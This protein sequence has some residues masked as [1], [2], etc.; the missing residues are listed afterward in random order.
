MKT[1]ALFIL[2]AFTMVQCS[3]DPCDIQNNLECTTADNDGDGVPN[4]D[5][6]A[7]EDPCVPNVPALESLLVGTWDYSGLASGTMKMNED[8]SYEDIS[9]EL[10][11]NGTVV[12]RIW[13][14]EAGRAVKWEVQNTEGLKS[15]VTLGILSTSCS[16]VVF[17]FSGLSI[18]FEKV[19]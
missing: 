11:N 13:S 4:G 9:N 3:P 6:V 15:S 8:F 16:R 5:D 2:L 10:V 7:P 14:V 12:S 19:E 1:Y 17:D 18:T